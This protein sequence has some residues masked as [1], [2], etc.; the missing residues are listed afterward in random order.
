M[1]HVPRRDHIKPETWRDQPDK[2]NLRRPHHLWGDRS[3][4]GYCLPMWPVGPDFAHHTRPLYQS[5]QTMTLR[6]TLIA[7]AAMTASS[8]SAQVLGDLAPSFNACAETH[9][10]PATYFQTMLDDGWTVTPDRDGAIARI[11]DSF[12]PVIGPSG[13]PWDEMM[14]I[15]AETGNAPAVELVG[16]R[17]IYEQEG[18]LLLIGGY[19]NEFGEFRVDC[20][21]VLPTATL[22]DAVFANTDDQAMLPELRMAAFAG[23]DHTD[24]SMTRM[25][26]VQLIP[27][28]PPDP[29]LAGAN[30]L[31]IQTIIPS[32]DPENYDKGDG[33]DH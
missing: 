9:R 7:L 28:T 2:T 14:Q 17:N 1:A 20:W 24:G 12:L 11:S 27:D 23:P 22:T 15:R 26:A 8:A 25:M 30:G 21:L 6:Y 10:D 16:S 4:A 18:H 29:P 32:P 33:H 31:Y 3:R 5:A 19:E 13:L